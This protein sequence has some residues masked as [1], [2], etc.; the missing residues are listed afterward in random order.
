MRGKNLSCYSQLR[1]FMGARKFENCESF[2][3]SGCRKNCS[4]SPTRKGG[5]EGIL[6]ERRINQSSAHR[7]IAKLNL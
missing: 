6:E 3:R 2:A 1:G 5:H 7:I 4:V